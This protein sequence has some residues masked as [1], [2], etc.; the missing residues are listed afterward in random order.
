VKRH[1]KPAA[2]GMTKERLETM[3]EFT[4]RVDAVLPKIKATGKKQVLEALAISVAEE[5]NCS[6]R[7]LYTHLHENEKNS[8]SGIGEGVAV[9][10]LQMPGI[11]RRIVAVATLDTPVS[12][13]APDSQGVDI[14]CLLL[15]PQSD[16][17][18][19]LRGL[20]RISR[21]FKNGMLCDKL[22]GTK[23]ADTIKALVNNPEGWLIAA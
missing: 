10:P 16:G 9:I 15:S 21:I 5:A 1:K 8:S 17:P 23:D 4:L 14:V 3:S 18:V 6:P 19:H 12:F 13:S 2:N 11:P 22:R 20:S 7:I